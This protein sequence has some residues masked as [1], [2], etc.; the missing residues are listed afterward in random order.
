MNMI[1]A[2]MQNNDLLRLGILS[3]RLSSK[4]IKAS[5]KNKP[6]WGKHNARHHSSQMADCPNSASLVSKLIYVQSVQ[7]QSTWPAQSL[8]W[9]LRLEKQSLSTTLSLRMLSLS[10]VF[11]C[12]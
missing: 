6:S 1:H 2:P 5:R 12:S 8:L 4:I 7:Q 10:V 9:Y 11:A 3:V